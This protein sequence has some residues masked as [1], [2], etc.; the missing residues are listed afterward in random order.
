MPDLRSAFRSG[1]PA[2]LSDRGLPVDPASVGRPDVG[3]TSEQFVETTPEFVEAVSRH[4]G[5]QQA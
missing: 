3:Q 1:N 5:R 2:V 4:M